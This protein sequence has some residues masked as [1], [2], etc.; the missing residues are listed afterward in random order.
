MTIIS[1][2]DRVC[3]EHALEFWSGLLEYTRGRSAP[4]VK[5]DQV[6]ACPL[7]EERGAQHLRAS[8]IKSVGPSPG[9]HVG[10]TMPIAS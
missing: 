5:A 4:C 2:P 6:C 8:A 7:C 3:A 9:D 1:T 10:F